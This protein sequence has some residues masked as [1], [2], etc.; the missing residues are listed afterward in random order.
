[1]GWAQQ[2]VYC[3]F[4]ER[5]EAEKERRACVHEGGAEMMMMMASAGL[6]ASAALS[7]F[8]LMRQFRRLAALV[9][10]KLGAG[11][12]QLHEGEEIQRT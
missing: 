9:A 8:L 1:M 10:G 3:S 2:R 5:Q 7:T 11:Q 4:G 6:R 12:M